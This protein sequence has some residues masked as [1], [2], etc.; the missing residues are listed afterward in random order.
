MRLTNNTFFKNLH[1]PLLI[2][3]I[4]IKHKESAV[5][6]ESLPADHLSFEKI[7]KLNKSHEK[8]QSKYKN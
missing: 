6:N 5:Y 8:E 2:N 3:I 1:T 4:S 7:K